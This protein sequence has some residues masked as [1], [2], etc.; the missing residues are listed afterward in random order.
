MYPKFLTSALIALFATA[1]AQASL[2]ATDSFFVGTGGYNSGSLYGI[3]P[4]VSNSGFSGAWSNENNQ[5]TANLQASAE[6]LSHNLVS[7][8]TADGSIFAVANNTG[9]T[10]TRAF[11]GTVNA[12]INDLIT[13]NGTLYFSGLVGGENWSHQA[14]GGS[15]VQLG[16]GADRT[17]SQLHTN[18]GVFARVGDNGAFMLSVTTSGGTTKETSVASLAA[19]QTY[20]FTTSID[21]NHSVGFHR[22]TMNLY[23]SDA[24]DP[25]NP[26]VTNFDDVAAADFGAAQLGYL[27]FNHN[28]T[29]N[30]TTDT[31]PRFDEFRMGTSLDAVL[32]PEPGTLALVG[33]ALGSLLFFRRR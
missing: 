11:D 14:S 28:N 17:H 19:G 25:L 21:F 29:G 20:L 1:T 10:V 8:S 2:I 30:S 27:V 26:T 16:L 23:D 4:T 18:G 12:T 24:T 33:I 32:I 6:S 22:I 31:T 7:G 3:N 13:N 9:R 15:T 5:T